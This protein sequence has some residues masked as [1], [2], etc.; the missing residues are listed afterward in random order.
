MLIRPWDAGLDEVEWQA[1]FTEGN[2]F[3]HLAVNGVR[4]QPPL[5]LPTHFTCH[6]DHLLVH[7]ARS[8]PVWTTIEDAP[9]VIFTV[10]GDY[11]HVPGSWRARCRYAALRHGS[12]VRIRRAEIPSRTAPPPTT[13]SSNAARISTRRP[14]ASSAAAWTASVPGKPDA[15][16]DDRRFRRSLPDEV[17]LSSRSPRERISS[18]LQ[19][20]NI[21]PSSQDDF[22]TVMTGEVLRGSVNATFST[23]RPRKSVHG[24][25]AILPAVTPVRRTIPVTSPKPL[26]GDSAGTDSERAGRFRSR[27]RCSPAAD[28]LSGGAQAPRWHVHSGDVLTVRARP[29]GTRSRRFT[30]SPGNPRR[31]RA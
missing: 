31:S 27:W 3:G 1:W 19:A 7:L 4:G 9:N 17:P 12:Q 13:R 15:G 20:N 5:V 2:D 11:A 25:L 8:N 16:S 14:H 10:L 24:M 21:C 18:L 6:G 26:G 28:P 29:N 30:V 22:V 23:L